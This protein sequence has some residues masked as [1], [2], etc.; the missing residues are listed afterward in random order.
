MTK[1][2]AMEPKRKNGTRLPTQSELVQEVWA[3]P[4]NNVWIYANKSRTYFEIT[5]RHIGGCFPRLFPLSWAP[6][7]VVAM[8]PKAAA[9][10]AANM[11]RAYR[12]SRLARGAIQ[13]GVAPDTLA[14]Q[15]ALQTPSM[16]RQ[17]DAYRSGVMSG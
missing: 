13:S 15:K 2:T 6:D 12:R 11:I 1:E 9:K 14:R 10:H 5:H 3:C 4:H 7:M 8:T 16:A 17:A